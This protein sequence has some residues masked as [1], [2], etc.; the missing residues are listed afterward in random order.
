MSIIGDDSLAAIGK[1]KISVCSV[2]RIIE[3]KKAT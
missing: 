3:I 1:R 2:I